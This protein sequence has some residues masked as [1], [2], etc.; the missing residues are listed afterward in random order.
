[1]Q[2][3]WVQVKRHQKIPGVGEYFD[4][5]PREERKKT[6]ENSRKGGESF[7]GILGWQSF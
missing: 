6:M 5:I 1:M 4:G 7:D 2:F 3:Q